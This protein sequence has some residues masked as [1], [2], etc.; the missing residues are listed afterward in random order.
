MG[1]CVAVCAPGCEP[2]QTC[3]VVA[4]AAT[5]TGGADA[6]PDAPAPDDVGD[7]PSEPA[8]DASDG[9]SDTPSEPADDAATGDAATDAGSEASAD[10]PRDVAL[11]CTPVCSL[12]FTCVAGACVP[13]CNPPCSAA[14][15]CS[16][17]D[18][19]TVCLRNAADAGI[20]AAGDR[21]PAPDAGI[22]AASDRAEA[23]VDA[24]PA[25]CGL[26]GQACCGFDPMIPEQ[27]GACRGANLCDRATRRC[28]AYTPEADECTT[29]GE[30]PAGQVCATGERC[31]GGTRSCL[32]CIPRS[33]AGTLAAGAP[34]GG[35][36]TGA[37]ADGI[38]A[39][40]R[41]TR[42]CVP[43][44]AG[45]SVCEGFRAGSVCAELSQ[46]IRLD[47]GLS[48]PVTF[49]ACI[50]GC[51][52]DADCADAAGNLRCGL[53]IRR[54]DD[55]YLQTCRIPFGAIAPGAAC[56]LVP[57]SRT[58]PMMFCA[59]ECFSVPTSMTTGYCSAFCAT[60]AD[61]PAS[62]RFCRDVPFFRPSGGAA[63]TVPVRMCE[64]R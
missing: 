15:T 7:A 34:C 50:R 51:A 17:R 47:G 63:G 25:P 46:S 12:G 23:A 6:G 60:D 32:R 57:A 14:E 26:T 59:S 37:C 43:G 40:G 20:D 62:A 18:G 19:F 41:C 10:A 33:A 42:A 56:P 49:G 16:V 28:A 22:D 8:D 38:C 1:S 48:N 31:S 11:T 53:S 36:I 24:A 45:D 44:A 58:D 9:A 3:A 35:T 2:G 29:T 52:R 54:I 4:G 13:L 30:C 55:R 27:T 64:Q 39:N 21:P 5:C 61:C